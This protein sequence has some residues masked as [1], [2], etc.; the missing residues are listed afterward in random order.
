MKQRRFYFNKNNYFRALCASIFLLGS[1]S[2]S[3]VLD[4]EQ[5]SNSEVLSFSLSSDLVTATIQAENYDAQSGIKKSN[6]GSAVGYVNNNDWI[7]FDDF[8]FDGANTVSVRAASARSGGTIEFRAGGTSSDLLGTV[9]VSGTGGWTNFQTFTANISDNSNNSDLYLVFKG[10]GG[11]LFDVDSFQFNGSTS[12]PPTDSS[13]NIALG[14][15]AEQSSTLYGTV[16]RAI[17]GNTS[18][19]WRQGS[20]THTKN[21]YQPW[22]QV[23]LGG[24]YAIGDIKIWNRT[25]SCCISRLS[26][27]D[28]FVYNSAG[29][30][31]YKT[32]IT[33]APTPSVTIN[34]GG[35]FGSRVRVKLKGTNVLSLAEV[36]VFSGED[37]GGGTVDPPSGDFPYDVLGLDDWKIT[38]PRSNDGDDISDE[39]YITASKN[40]DSSDPSLTVYS[41][42]FFY[43]SDDGVTFECPAIYSL[44]K[45]SSGTSN[46]RTELREMPNNDNEDGWSASG[47]TV[48]ELEF[49]ARVLQTSS[50]SKVA[51]AQIHDDGEANWDDL[52]RVQIESDNPNAVEGDYGKIYIMGDMAEGLSSEGVPTQSSSDRTIIENYRLGD[53]MNIR[54]TFNNN[55]IRIYVDGV[56]KQT[57]TGADCPSNYFKA[58]AYNQSMNSSSSGRSIVEFRSLT[59]TENF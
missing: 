16:S 34:T 25:D 53:W 48:R 58:G 8:D 43:V 17:D 2:Q 40:D 3:E 42:E 49:S 46:T 7:R 32:T 23:H 9:S 31:V 44:P 27:F 14:K 19:V 45:T 11:Y 35:V 41:D 20:V 13:T 29:T 55:T 38:L 59:V 10:G 39:V 18:G 37:D 33:S 22:W 36:Q 5:S 56:I 57:Y 4:E 6:G 21:T 30:Q 1:C 15:T 28:V 26:N 50:T 12:N 47:S 51:F 24:D 54:V 52:I